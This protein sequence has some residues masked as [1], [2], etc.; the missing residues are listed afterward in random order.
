MTTPTTPNNPQ[1]SSSSGDPLLESLLNE[2]LA[3]PGTNTPDMQAVSQH[4]LA[5]TTPLLPGTT[6][7]AMSKALGQ[8]LGPSI[9][10]IDCEPVANA[11]LANAI[12]SKTAAAIQARAKTAHKPARK[13][14]R[15]SQWAD[16]HLDSL[17]NEALAPEETKI[18]QPLAT[19]IAAATTPSPKNQ[20]AL[21]T[22]TQQPTVLSTIG[23]GSGTNSFYN[24][25]NTPRLAMAAGL[26]LLLLTIGVFAVLLSTENLSDTGSD[27][28]ASIDP[29]A[30]NATSN[31]PSISAA[32]QTTTQI[33][34]GLAAAPNDSRLTVSSLSAQLAVIETSP[35]W[36]T[37]Q[38]TLE[39]ALT[40]STLDEVETETW[41]VF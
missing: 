22:V 16:Q 4:I 38:D 6:Q 17:L 39:T 19:S 3:A 23:Q 15:Q 8:A 26:G 40:L 5:G 24:I 33:A 1:E 30:D 10:S 35:L 13:S 12:L 25:F 2:A 7:Q 36:A 29:N 11:P 27:Q 31:T 28:I 20:T 34:N 37:P 9:D 32:Q 18:T 21:Q 41:T 14:A